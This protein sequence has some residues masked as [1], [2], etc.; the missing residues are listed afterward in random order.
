MFLYGLLQWLLSNNIN[1]LN[2]NNKW[3]L[4]N[5]NDNNNN[6]ENNNIN[7]A[8]GNNKWI[9]NKNNN[10]NNNNNIIGSVNENQIYSTYPI[11]IY[12]QLAFGGHCLHFQVYTINSVI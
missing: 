6:N 10:N 5:N 2:S 4:N 9:L 1:N 12:V 8:N 3:I 11:F 7:N